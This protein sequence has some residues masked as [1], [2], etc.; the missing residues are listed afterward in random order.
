MVERAVRSVQGVVRTMRSALEE[1]W[2]IVL[3]E[4]HAIW[5]W[6]VEYAAF[7]IS[8]CEV[9]KDGKTAYERS[10]GN[11]VTVLGLEFGE[12]VLWRKRKGDRMAK[13]ST[14]YNEDISANM[15]DIAEERCCYASMERLDISQELPFSSRSYDYLIS[16]GTTNHL[17]KLLVKSQLSRLGVFFLGI[18]SVVAIDYTEYSDNQVHLF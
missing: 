16:V 1:K 13:L 3:D 9:G 7:L 8:R 14:E 2:G 15:L 17:G 10:K 4:G 12:K 18:I 11:R 5:A 6:M